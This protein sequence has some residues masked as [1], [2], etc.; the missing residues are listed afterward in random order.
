MKSYNNWSTKFDI[1]FVFE[2]AQSSTWTS[3]DFYFSRKE[4]IYIQ[5]YQPQLK[6]N[7]LA[8]YSC[9]ILRLYGELPVERGLNF[10]TNLTKCILGRN[11]GKK[12]VE[13]CSNCCF[14]LFPLRKVPYLWLFQ[15][16]LIKVPLNWNL[17]NTWL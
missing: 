8:V 2:I 14:L 9:P 13:F 17:F 16:K 11:F 1:S 4:I 7:R 5:F 6:A 10:R 12:F 3:V 15:I